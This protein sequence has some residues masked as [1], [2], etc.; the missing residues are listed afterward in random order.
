[1]AQINKHMK[2]LCLNK[3]NK[4]Q[5]P[6]FGSII[7]P[8]HKKIYG[9]H[10][11][12]LAN[13]QFVFHRPKPLFSSDQTKS[14]IFFAQAMNIVLAVHPDKIHGLSLEIVCEVLNT[15]K[16][17]EEQMSVLTALKSKPNKFKILFLISFK[18]SCSF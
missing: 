11:G 1:M 16:L 7:H 17:K 8:H 5:N 14:D 13:G 15:G 2:L 4:H 3:Q 18:N 12:K 10:R 6:Q 9:K